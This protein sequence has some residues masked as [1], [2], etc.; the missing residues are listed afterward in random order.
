VF[1]TSDGGT[2]AY[3]LRGGRLH[4]VWQDGA[5]GTSPV[6]AGGLLYVYDG[7]AGKLRI[8]RPSNGR[9]VATLPAETGHWSSPIVVGGRV[10]LPVGGSSSD[11]AT[12]G[13]VIV[14]HL[15]GR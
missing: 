11:D 14:Y 12:S 10:I 9:T 2:A 6:L 15:A 13:T 4:V 8:L 7:G 5:G 1:V 3:A